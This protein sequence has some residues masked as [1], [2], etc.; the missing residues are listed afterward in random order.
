MLIIEN[1]DTL[2][3]GINKT[4]ENIE[5]INSFL[6]NIQLSDEDKNMLNNNINYFQKHI[7]NLEI[8]SK[9]YN[10]LDRNEQQQLINI[11]LDLYND[12]NKILQVI[13]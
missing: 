9:T 1:L 6:N 7:K 11:V 13:S 10:T 2:L 8:L 3:H 4:K 12:A 5:L